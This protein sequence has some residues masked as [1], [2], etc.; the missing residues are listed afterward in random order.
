MKKEIHK[1]HKMTKW[2]DTIV[3]LI[4]TSRF[5]RIRNCVYCNAEHAKTAAGEAMHDELKVKCLKMNVV[6]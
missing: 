2:R 3:T 6:F 1:S 4:A 5:G